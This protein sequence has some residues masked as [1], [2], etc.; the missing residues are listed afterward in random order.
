[1]SEAAT[2]HVLV[3]YFSHAGENWV[4]GGVRYIEVGNTKRLA[5]TIANKLESRGHR[6][7][8]YEIKASD[9]YSVKYEET[10]KRAEAETDADARP[11]IVLPVPDAS[12][13]DV[14]FLGYP[15]WCGKMPRV[16]MTF[17]ETV[18]F[19]AIAV[20]PF[21]THEGGG[22]N[23]SEREVL[24]AAPEADVK[25]GFAMIGSNVEHPGEP[26]E[27]WLNAFDA[28]RRGDR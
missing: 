3:A 23:Q 27:H 24:K 4:S 7:D 15:M 12:K 10:T 9:P 11:G 13:Y 25:P 21:T 28:G 1:M 16:V 2:P 8:R 26:L 19:G 20:W 6:V 14:L 17:L 22:I 18:K 5:E